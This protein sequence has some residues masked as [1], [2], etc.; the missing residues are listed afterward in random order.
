MRRILAIA[1]FC[2]AAR[3]GASVPKIWTTDSARDFSAGTAHG[4]SA[5]PDGRLALTREARAIAG[6]TA[7]KIF[8]VE[9]EKS[10]ALLFACGDEGQIFRQEPGKPATAFVT[11]PESEVT[12]LAIGPD[13]AVYAGTS[14]HGKVYRIEKGKPLPYFEPQT[15]YIWAFAFDRGALYVATGVPGRIYRVTAPGEGTVFDDAGDEHVRC[16]LMDAQHRLWAGTS[17]KGLVI[18]VGPDGVARTIYDSEKAE[19]SSLAAAPE[20]QIFAAAVSTKGAGAPAGPVRPPVP[21]P[22][23][24][25]KES[26]PSSP[27]EG[28]ATVTVT[29]TT[30]LVP[31]APPSSG[32]KGGES[33]EIVEIGADDAAVPFWRSDDELVHSCR[34]DGASGGLLVATGPHGRVY[35]VRKGQASLSA[36]VDEKRVVLA[37]EDVLATDSPA[38]AY[39]RV[40][41]RSGEFFSSIQDTGRTSRFGAFRTDAAVPKGAALT[42]AF[43]SGN[44]SYPDATWTPWTAPVPA[45]SPGKIAAAPGRFLQWKAAFQRS[46]EGSPVLS[47]VEC[48]YQNDNAR[49]QVESVAVGAPPREAAAAFAPA[50]TDDGS[51]AG[52]I[53]SVSDEKPGSP[54][55]EGRGYL[56]VTW[57]ASDP[58]GDE[59][60]ADVDFRPAG[61]PERWVPMR[62]G[63]RGNAFGF[64][65]RLLPDGRYLFRVTAS[66]RTGNPDDPRSDSM[67]SDPVL[68]DN[69]PPVISLVSSERGKSGPVLR[70]KVSDALSPVAAVGWSVDAGPWTRAA[71]DDGMTDS[72]QE[73]YTISLQPEIRGAYVLIRAVDAAGNTSSLSV[74][75]P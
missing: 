56:A 55:A 18:R 66:D 32:P 58:D 12:A 47:R 67:V 69:T 9:M 5:L 53:F 43:R 6:L 40:P 22:P 14:P 8:A 42:I 29:A 13:G 38:S 21:A 37:T 23:K 46:A 33:S 39:R 44:S 2:G 61:S 11:L 26:A 16:L 27:G 65:S 20:G 36:S 63:V 73:S 75:A 15:E 1:A 62:R 64:D 48:A 74:P 4:V 57:K 59:L 30:S 35:L 24:E 3:A 34:W 7:T 50:S 19:I 31:P 68:V 49:P 28:G 70:V 54:R 10:G 25:K 60:V 71:A 72:P 17:G 41:A 52:S 45:D 51:S